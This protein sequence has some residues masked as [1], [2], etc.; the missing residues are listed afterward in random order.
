MLMQCKLGLQI[1]LIDSIGRAAV[2]RSLGVILFTA[3]CNASGY[4]KIKDSTNRGDAQETA[5]RCRG[6]IPDCLHLIIAAHGNEE[7]IFMT[8][9]SEYRFLIARC[10]GSSPSADSFFDA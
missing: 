5:A 2:T 9:S 7:N 4:S 3:I 10:S 1:S 6:S 8:M